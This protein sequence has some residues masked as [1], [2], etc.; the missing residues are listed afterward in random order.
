MGSK[1]PVGRSRTVIDKTRSLV[2]QARRLVIDSTYLAA[3]ARDI[4]RERA[5]QRQL[6]SKRK[7]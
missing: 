6:V 2:F 5:A 3:K 7:P 4:R 1:D